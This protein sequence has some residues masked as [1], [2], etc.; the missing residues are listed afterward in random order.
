MAS[1]EQ[2]P[3]SLAG[4][5]NFRVLVETIDDII[6]IGD[7]EGRILYANP[8]TTAVLG[9]TP[10]ELAGMMVLDL[11]AASMREEAA[12]ILTEMF[13][14]TRQTCPLPLQHKNGSLV[15][16]ETRV[17]MGRW[18]GVDCIFGLCKNLTK[19]QEA[20]Q[21]FDR[22]FRMN[23]ALM[24]VN[25]LPDR[26][27]FDVNDAFL[28]TLGYT[29]AEV[30]GRSAAELDL[31]VDVEMQEQ[32]SAELREHGRFREVELKVR[33]KDGRIIESLFSG[34]LIQSQGHTYFLTVAIDITERQQTVRELRA[35]LAEIRELQGILP[36]CAGCKKIRNDSGYWE[37][38][39][40]YI[41]LHT[42]AQFS[43]GMCPDCMVRLYPDFGRK[44]S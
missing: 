16:A 5:E 13:Q 24:A 14:G 12:V 44:D 21:K 35:A 32:V 2:K 23:P 3:V 26:T 34:D 25:R 8:A 18:N 40:T 27:F 10:Q 20:L 37:Q 17:W 15:P 42:R 41:E 22:F 11:N 28:R 38:V 29:A 39:E 6:V 33:A 30:I 7:L 4:D 31:F 36:I 43:H 9:Y 1:P 19:E